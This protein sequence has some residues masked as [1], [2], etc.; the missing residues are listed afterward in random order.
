MDYHAW[1]TRVGTTELAHTRGPRR[2]HPLLL[3]G[4]AAAPVFL[5][6]TLCTQNVLSAQTW[7]TSVVSVS[8]CV[9]LRLCVQCPLGA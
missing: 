7:L 8:A 2:R 3:L 4:W 5:G 9:E 1:G 6:L